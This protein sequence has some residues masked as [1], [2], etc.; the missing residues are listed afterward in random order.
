M[1]GYELPDNPEY[2]TLDFVADIYGGSIPDLPRL[3]AMTV[4]AIAAELAEMHPEYDEEEA[5][6]FA[7]SVKA[8]AVRTSE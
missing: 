6:A 7:A 4:E 2:P 3:A 1:T 8:V 5:S